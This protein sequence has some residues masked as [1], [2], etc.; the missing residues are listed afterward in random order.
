MLNIKNKMESIEMIQKL[1]LNKFP[2]QLF[3]KNDE[4]CV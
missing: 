1:N 3:K 2:E 4:K